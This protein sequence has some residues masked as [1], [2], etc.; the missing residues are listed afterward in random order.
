MAAHILIICVMMS[1]LSLSTQPPEPHWHIYAPHIPMNVS[2]NPLNPTKHTHILH[3][4][5]AYNMYWGK[6]PRDIQLYP[7]IPA[8]ESNY[9]PL[10]ESCDASISKGIRRRISFHCFFSFFYFSSLFIS[11]RHR[12][13]SQLSVKAHSKPVLHHFQAFVFQK[14]SIFQNLD[15]SFRN[16][17]CAS[18][19]AQPIPLII[20]CTPGDRPKCHEP[21]Y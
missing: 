4:R 21:V 16:P 14:P 5:D 19:N 6:P 7:R 9:K 17:Q 8:Q 18:G 13:L 3:V 20:T 11:L 12:Q 2:M 1:I 15:C 10:I